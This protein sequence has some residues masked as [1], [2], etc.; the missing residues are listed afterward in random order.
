VPSTEAGYAVLAAWAEEFG[1]LKRVGIEGGGSFGVGLTR[2][3]RAR[4]VEVV[5]LNRPN[6]QHRRLL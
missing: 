1:V 6:R 5:E 3:L 4:G 2:F